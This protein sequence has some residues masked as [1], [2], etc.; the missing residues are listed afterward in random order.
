MDFAEKVLYAVF[1]VS[2]FY[3][4]I[5]SVYEEIAGF[6][7]GC[8]YLQEDQ[9]NVVDFQ[10]LTA[11][12]Y[13]FVVSSDGLTHTLVR[14]IKPHAFQVIENF[15]A[16]NCSLSANN[17]YK[18]NPFEFIDVYHII[19]P[20]PDK[21]EGKIDNKSMPYRSIYIEKNENIKTLRH[22]GYWEM[23]IMTPRWAALSHESYGWGPGLLSLGL[24]KA[25]QKMEKNS[26]QM[27]DKAMDPPLG[28]PPSLKDQEVDLSPGGLN[29]LGSVE[30]K[31]QRMVEIDLNG[32]DF[33]NRKIERYELKIQQL[34]YNDL[35]LL[36]INQ[37]IAKMTATEVLERKEEKMLMLGPTIERLLH[38]LLDPIIEK[39]LNI[40][41]RRGLIPPPPM[42]MIQT[43]YRIDYISVLA[44]AQKLV[45]A[46]SMNS[47]LAMASAIAELDPLTIYKTNWD[48]FL[49]EYGDMVGFPAK[50]IRDA[51]EVNQ[52][53]QAAIEQ[54]QKEQEMLESQAT[55][56]DIKNLGSAKSD[57]G[58]AL[59]DLKEAVE[60]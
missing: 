31:I 49:D 10:Y 15:G 27:T 60:I 28:L 13:R 55:T 33:M 23:P 24:A 48:T 4:L 9:K 36:I 37:P 56:E 30:E 6:G 59:A 46:Q 42:E 58:T 25:I 35:F 51:N 17:L 40:C 21:K 45:M 50:I 29:T 8:L 47:Y 54:Q 14:H 11:G 7:S 43:P 19:E 3:Q 12:D 1:K 16:E 5:H 57:A 22:T 20:N 39:T 53:R 34:F 18:N 52:M 38:E 2:N 41:L 32:L 26:L 44:Q